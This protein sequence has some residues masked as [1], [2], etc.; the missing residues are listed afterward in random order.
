MN[1][2]APPQKVGTVSGP[3]AEP[4]TP[5]APVSHSS[6]LT[7]KAT[8]LPPF[9][10]AISLGRTAMASASFADSPGPWSLPASLLELKLPAAPKARRRSNWRWVMTTSRSRPPTAP[11]RCRPRRRGAAG[12]AGR[13]RRVGGSG[14]GRVD[15]RPGAGRRA[16]RPQSGVPAEGGALGGKNYFIDINSIDIFKILVILEYRAAQWERQDS[17]VATDEFSRKA[18]AC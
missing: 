15:S 13:L 17:P 8:R 11:K 1:A 9:S 6:Y 16:A 3:R 18:R 14:L 5:A 12:E 10:R 4:P 7:E 2:A